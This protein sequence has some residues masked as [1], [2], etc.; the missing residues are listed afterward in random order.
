MGRR[1]AELAEEPARSETGYD[2]RVFLG[3]I[4]LLKCW[5]Q[6]ADCPTENSPQTTV[7][8]RWKM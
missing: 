6:G 1:L 8:T 2:R 3:I 7:Y 5:G 4:H